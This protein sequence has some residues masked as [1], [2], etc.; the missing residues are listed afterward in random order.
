LSPRMTCNVPA[1]TEEIMNKMKHLLVES[2]EI[3]Y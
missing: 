1:V 2:R 3:M